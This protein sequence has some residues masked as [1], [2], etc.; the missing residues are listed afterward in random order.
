M[1]QLIISGRSI[2]A[3]GTTDRRTERR[4]PGT[5]TRCAR[6]VALGAAFWLSVAGVA[7]A[8]INLGGFGATSVPVLTSGG[9]VSPPTGGGGGG[10]GG[11]GATVSQLQSQGYTCTAR[12]ADDVVCRRCD[13]EPVSETQTCSISL[14]KS[15]GTCLGSRT[16]WN[17]PRDVDV[18]GW[19]LW[20]PEFAL[21][22]SYFLGDFNGDGRRDLGAR[23]GQLVRA[24][25]SRG[26]YFAQQ[27]GPWTGPA[28]VENAASWAVSDVN[29]DGI[30]D[31]LAVTAAGHLSVGI[32]NGT[33]VVST[34]EAAETWCEGLGECLIGDVNGD[35]FPDLV[36]VMLGAVG[37]QRAGDAWVSLGHEIPGFPPLP[38]S[39]TP[40]D[41][42]GDGV[43]DR[44]DDCVTV[45]NPNQL[46]SDRDGFGNACDADLNN[47]GK[48][49]QADT[50]LMIGCLGARVS[51]RPACAAH[52]LDGDGLILLFDVVIMNAAQGGVPGPGAVSQGPEI[53]LFAPADGTIFAVGTTKAWVAGW[54]PNVPAGSVQVRVGGVLV[55][56]SG[57]DNRFSTFVDLPAA[58]DQ[59]LF[60]PIVV[61][62]VRGTKRNVA[63]RAVL[64]GDR[65]PVG[66]RAHTA[67]GGKLSMAGLDRLESYVRSKVVADVMAELPDKINGYRHDADCQYGLP[68]CWDGY[69]ISNAEIFPPAV[70]VDLQGGTLNV[71]VWTPS[72]EFDWHVNGDGWGCGDHA[73]AWDLTIDVRYALE[74]GAGGRIE[75]RELHEPQVTADFEISGCWEFGHGRVEDGV[76]DGF[77][78]ALDDPDDYQGQHQP[79]QTGPI[80]GA[81]E[82]ILAKL[83]L[84]GEVTVF[85][86]EV[87]V[88]LAAARPGASGPAALPL[89][90]PIALSYDTRFEYVSQNASGFSFLLG[91]GIEPT[92]PRSGLGSPSGAYQIP[93]AVAPT[94]PGAL[95]SGEAY[96]LAAAV[97][98]N[99]LNE[100]LEAIT[101]SGL[102]AQQSLSVTEVTVGTTKIPLTAGLLRAVIPAFAAY[103]N[104]ERITARVTPG[105][106]PPVVSGRK[107]PN[108]EPVDLHAA[109]VKIELLDQ[110]QKAAVALR[111]DFRIGVDVGLGGGGN[112]S[113]TAVA[114]RLKVLDYAIVEN[115]INANPADV[116]LRILCIDRP[117]NDP[118]PCA[119]EGAL[120]KGLNIVLKTVELPSL[121]D[122]DPSTEDFGLRPRCMQPLADGTLV[123]TF[124]LLLP[125]EVGPA[126]T[127]GGLVV[128]PG[129][130]A[131]AT[132]GGGTR[133]G[134]LGTLGTAP[135]LTASTAAGSTIPAPQV[136]ATSTGTAPAKQVTT[137][138]TLGTSAVA[139]VR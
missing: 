101:R 10:G 72:L 69:E 60:R 27:P 89:A 1:D 106:V 53:E 93:G 98:P 35:G 75:V 122:D 87:P 49:D 9:V 97:T 77:T 84:Q 6:L 76:I 119:L 65:A 132:D 90:D 82:D 133:P 54:V 41:K 125:G 64:I 112:G 32:S 129:C 40:K 139:A 134:T 50:N 4:E 137:A 126:F 14:C 79:Y 109:Q 120:E 29:R 78:N 18:D 110:K 127:G 92:A 62:A 47:D 30:L 123:A 95:P 88:V 108:G 74:M 26:T 136:T 58:A 22:S 57:P 45:A 21:G 23:Q 61:E 104:E 80:G 59:R 131:G 102:L 85:E 138:T 56:V 25:L 48:V 67:F 124:G 20:T 121:A 17:V 63:R 111:V 91:A 71:H 66:R 128:D 2:H 117:A 107:G 11:F 5:G 43:L 28:P 55:P 15:F 86:P 8:R 105:S 103:P 31:V 83:A 115:P 51:T 34:V 3:P 24:A 130:L 42:D 19:D 44:A 16:R 116:F 135:V 114:R 46:D 13:F 36:E 100:L 94:L 12:Q 81:I 52:D 96:H 37:G 118:F 38:A 39:A 7:S 70:I 73:I 68:I 99:G 113:L 33:Q